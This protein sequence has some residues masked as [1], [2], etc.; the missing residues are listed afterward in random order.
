MISV[1]WMSQLSDFYESVADSWSNFSACECEETWGNVRERDDIWMKQR[2]TSSSLPWMDVTPTVTTGLH[3]STAV[4]LAGRATLSA[5]RLS[6][7]WHL[8]AKEARNI[9]HINIWIQTQIKQICLRWS[10]SREIQS[11]WLSLVSLY[12]CNNLSLIWIILEI[13][14]G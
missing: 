13:H 8:L 7:E 9:Y 5:D 6:H 1:D 14:I 4:W 3:E 2:R 11:P 12:S 10:D